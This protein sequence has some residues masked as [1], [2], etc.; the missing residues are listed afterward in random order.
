MKIYDAAASGASSERLFLP[1]ENLAKQTRDIHDL[2]PRK[3]EVRI[4]RSR[5]LL[6]H[7]ELYLA[8]TTA[9]VLTI[10]FFVNL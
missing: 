10:L 1:I 5:Y 8:M 2:L 3:G 6:L 4:P 9:T 7:V